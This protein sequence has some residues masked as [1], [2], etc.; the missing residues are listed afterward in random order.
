[1][2]IEIVA[3]PLRV[4]YSPINNGSSAA[5]DDN[6]DEDDEDDEVD[7]EEEGLVRMMI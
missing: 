3:L 5:D 7:G 4:A 2:G 1:M 6:V